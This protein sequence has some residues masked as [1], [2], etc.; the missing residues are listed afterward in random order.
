M[1][2]GR[3]HLSISIFKTGMEHQFQQRDR[4]KALRYMHTGSVLQERVL[5]VRFIKKPLIWGLYPVNWF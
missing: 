4:S 3:T 2:K 1:P 5:F